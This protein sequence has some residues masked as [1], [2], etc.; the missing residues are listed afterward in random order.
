MQGQQLPYITQQK[1]KKHWHKTGTITEVL[2]HKQYK[3]KINGSGHITP[4]N[5]R[6]LC[7]ITPQSNVNPIPLTPVTVSSN[8][9]NIS[10]PA[11]IIQREHTTLHQEW[12]ILLSVSTDPLDNP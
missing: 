3:V 5:R 8:P 7:H 11:G 1:Y 12:E 10:N 9:V 6:F 4:C 2:P